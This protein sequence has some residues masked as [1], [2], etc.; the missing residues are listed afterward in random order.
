M[1]SMSKDCRSKMEIEATEE[2]IRF[3]T[4]KSLRNLVPISGIFGSR[5]GWCLMKKVCV[6]GGSGFLGSHV[7]DELT[8]SGY[9]VLIFDKAPSKWM[10]STQEM[11]I[12]DLLDPLQV[13]KVLA[14]CE[15]V[16]NFALADLN[17]GI[18]KSL[19]KQ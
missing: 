14:D 18:A 8:K 7:A 13:D 2:A 9:R 15:I 4:G 12:G 1:G 17:E 5:D 19:L 11:I 10:Q 3:F 16:Y 6:F